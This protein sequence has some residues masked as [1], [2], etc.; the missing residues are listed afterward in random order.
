VDNT[1]VIKNG[2]IR[3]VTKNVADYTISNI[4]DKGYDVFVG[5]HEDKMLRDL[6]NSAYTHAVVFSTGTEFLC[7]E[8]FFDLVNLLILQDFLI[9]GHVLD[10]KDAY[11]ELHNQCYVINLK[12]YRL[13]ECP[14]IGQ[15]Q[16]CYTHTQCK[17]LRSQENYHDDYTPVSIMPGYEFQDY[18]HRCHG[19]N[20]LSIALR[21]KLGVL[22][23]DQTLRNSKKYYYPDNNFVKECQW[24]YKRQFHAQVSFVHTSSNEQAPSEFV[25]KVTQIF[26]PASGTWWLN[27]LDQ[28][29]HCKVIFYDYNQKALDYWQEHSPK[30]SYIQ[31]EYVLA[32]LLSETI[33][34]RNFITTD[35]ALINLSNIFCYEATAPF[36]SL[37]YRIHQ[38]N[39]YVSLI[40]IQFP[41]SY[42]YFCNRAAT[43]FANAGYFDLAKNF[44]IYTLQELKT[45]TWHMDGAWSV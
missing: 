24:L 4:V 36:A 10:R 30:Y 18:M 20:I 22:I 32:D 12:L 29:Q 42:L 28:S 6:D 35:N 27:M 19:W 21:A 15:Q 7:G 8:T 26:T 39:S 11:Y 1:H 37:D 17:P 3:E 43:G 44:K 41:N 14:D 5:L 45:P 2:Y 38:E 34:L 33:D 13:L 40:K 23:F 9:A 16:L 25:D 31:Y